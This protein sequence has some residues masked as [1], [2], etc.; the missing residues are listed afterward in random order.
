MSKVPRKGGLKLRQ[1][2]KRQAEKDLQ[3][4][5]DGVDTDEEQPPTPAP[6]FAPKPRAKWSQKDM[7]EILKA[8]AKLTLRQDEDLRAMVRASFYVLE[9][10]H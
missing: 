7:E 3:K 5:K 8:T 4:G 9:L 1:G 6:K 10:T 2:Q